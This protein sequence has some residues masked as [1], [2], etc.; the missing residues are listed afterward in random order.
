MDQV[1]DWICPRHH[2]HLSIVRLLEGKWVPVTSNNI[3]WRTGG[4]AAAA[5]SVNMRKELVVLVK[6]IHCIEQ[7][8]VMTFPL[9]FNE[10]QALV[11]QIL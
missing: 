7:G 2:A 10:S 6:Q 1:V 8:I 11:Y 9:V 5:I 3:E 4:Q